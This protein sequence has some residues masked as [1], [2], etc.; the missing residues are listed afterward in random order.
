M[1]RLSKKEYD[2]FVSPS[3]RLIKCS[4]D[5]KLGRRRNK[6]DEYELCK[7]ISEHLQWHYPDILYH[8]DF[9]SGAKLTI[10]QAVQQK[11]LNTRKGYPDL[12]IIEPRNG[13]KGLYI[14]VKIAGT[15]LYQ[16]RNPSKYKDEHLQ[17]QAIYLSELRKRGFRAEFGIGYDECKNLIDNY[18]KTERIK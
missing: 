16:K 1:I 14:E 13:F 18:L 11:T 17:E 8:F 3:E 12:F 2:E 10:G 4:K 6:K 7:R 15:E 5:K 9:G